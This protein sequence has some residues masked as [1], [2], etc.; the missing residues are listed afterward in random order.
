M[1]PAC[2]Y[3][4]TEL[5][6]SGIHLLA[7]RSMLYSF[8]NRLKPK[9]IFA[10]VRIPSGAISSPLSSFQWTLSIL[11]RKS[12]ATFCASPSSTCSIS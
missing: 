1:Q 8:C 9:Y 7:K 11:Y 3:P 10:W 12:S 4:Y 6:I 5:D 2:P